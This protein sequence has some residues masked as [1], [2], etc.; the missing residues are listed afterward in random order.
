MEDRKRIS[1][2]MYIPMHDAPDDEYDPY[3]PPQCGYAV[4][5][6]PILPVRLSPDYDVE[7]PLW[8]DWPLDTR[9]PD[10]L[11]DR[12][13]SWQAEFDEN[14]RIGVGWVAD[15]AKEQWVAQADGLA[16]ALREVLLDKVELEVDLWPAHPN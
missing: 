6:T 11:R 13:A 10:D 4:P 15:E 3:C 9:L 16:R 1:P 14:F 12:L 5:G 7:L 8:G 2:P